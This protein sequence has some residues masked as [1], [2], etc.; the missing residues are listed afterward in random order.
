M[1]W[2]LLKAVRTLETGYENGL[3]LADWVA[4]L[5]RQENRG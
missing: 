5:V 2:H 1:L 3:R 4:F